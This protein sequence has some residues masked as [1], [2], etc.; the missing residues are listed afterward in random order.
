MKM[1]SIPGN[2]ARE[3]DNMAREEILRLGEEMSRLEATLLMLKE[4]YFT[5]HEKVKEV[6]TL[7][8]TVRVRI[9]Q[10]LHL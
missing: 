3:S 9:M 4:N 2:E 10:Y 7:K 6:P 1:A 8:E 5:V